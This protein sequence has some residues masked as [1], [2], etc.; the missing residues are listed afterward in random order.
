[1]AY[2]EIDFR[3]TARGL[4]SETID[5]LKNGFLEGTTVWGK[6]ASH[7]FVGRKTIRTIVFFGIMVFMSNATH[8]GSG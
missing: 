3:V 8:F 7:A 2:T 1:M 5:N 6:R 4:R